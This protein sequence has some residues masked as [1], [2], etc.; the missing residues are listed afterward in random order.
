MHFLP[1][2]TLLILYCVVVVALTI[3]MFASS[4]W[5]WCRF[6]HSH[7]PSAAPFWSFS[8]RTSQQDVVALVQCLF[9]VMYCRWLLA[10]LTGKCALLASWRQQRKCTKCI[11]DKANYKCAVLLFFEISLLF[12]FLLFFA[13]VC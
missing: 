3:I 12:L 9:V 11:S 7:Q 8:V 10:L 4:S 5:C 2:N 13:S 1:F 6:L